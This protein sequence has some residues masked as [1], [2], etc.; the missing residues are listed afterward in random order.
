MLVGLPEGI[1]KWG[2][3]Q[4]TWLV[5]KYL[6]ETS[7]RSLDFEAPNFGRSCVRSR[8]ESRRTGSHLGRR[9]LHLAT[10]A[11]CGMCFGTS[12][13]VALGILMFACDFW[14]RHNTKFALVCFS[15]D[16]SWWRIFKRGAGAV[17][18]LS[19][20]DHVRDHVIARWTQW[21]DPVGLKKWQGHETL[22]VP[23]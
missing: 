3:T 15:E 6:R 4:A 17:L 16:R 18:W 20:R 22:L 23:C 8:P 1:R 9:Y 14:V 11:Q 13:T 5:K 2:I 10:Q 12:I 19:E 21:S 7:A